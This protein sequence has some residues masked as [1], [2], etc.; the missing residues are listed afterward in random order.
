MEKGLQNGLKCILIDIDFKKFLGE[1]SEGGPPPPPLIL[2]P[3]SRLE[4]LG[5]SL[6]LEVPPPPLG[7]ALLRLKSPWFEH[8]KTRHPLLSCSTGST[9]DN[10]L[11]VGVQKCARKR[12]ISSLKSYPLAAENTPSN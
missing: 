2:S 4:P 6:R 11:E 3:C 1:M 9:Q 12:S 8:F 5:S 7:P 10:R